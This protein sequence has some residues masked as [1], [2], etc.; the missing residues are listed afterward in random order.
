MVHSQDAAEFQ[1][2]LFTI[3][4]VNAVSTQ[5][6]KVPLSIEGLPAEMQLGLVVHLV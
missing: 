4:E 2:E 6:I 1:E 5:D 3:S